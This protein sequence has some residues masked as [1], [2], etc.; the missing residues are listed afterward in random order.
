MESAMRKGF[1]GLLALWLAAHGVGRAQQPNPLP[2]L[3]T[4]PASLPPSAGTPDALPDTTDTN[5]LPV[6][7]AP[8]T[9]GAPSAGGTSGPST[10][11]DTQTT[12]TTQPGRGTADMTQQTNQA[13]QDALH[14]THLGPDNYAWFGANYLLWRVKSGHL[15][16]P[17]L[18][19]GG[20]ANAGIQNAPDTVILFGDQTLRYGTYSGVHFDAGFWFN[21]QH[22]W[23]VDA[24]GFD[25]FPRTLTSSFSSDAGGSPVLTRPVFDVSQ[26]PPLPTPFPVSFPGAF[27]GNIT[28][29]TSS[30][31]WGMETNLVRNLAETP[32]FRADLIAG[33]RYLDL[34]EDLDIVQNTTE[35]AG[36]LIFFN[37]PPGAARTDPNFVADFGLPVGSS[38]AIVDRFEARNQVYAGQIGGRLE[39]RQDWFSAHLVGKTA[40][41]PDHET[42]NVSGLT[43]AEVPGRSPS[44]VAGGLLALPGTNAGR[45]V[46]N[47]FVIVPEI[48][49]GVGVQLGRHFLL[50]AGY[51]FLY[52]NNV[53]RAGAGV[54][55]NVNSSFVP[56]SAFFHSPSGTIAPLAHFDR[57]DVFWA[58]GLNVGLEVRY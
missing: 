12:T 43:T 33:F 16:V 42:L 30:H 55:N 58:Q 4:P 15:N 32:H 5:P 45:Y 24:G 37:V 23:G 49:A 8:A 21:D 20:L 13:A 51:D 7:Q 9:E 35:L 48:E 36:G 14:D 34:V 57:K 41:G 10:G 19:T 6:A 11:S 39:Y 27:S 50:T 38:V 44:S 52:I 3:W 28:F 31:L 53:V 18:T 2:G 26:T 17:L 25:L 47:W 46:Q 54:D 29:S 22:T 56:T 40:F 1:V